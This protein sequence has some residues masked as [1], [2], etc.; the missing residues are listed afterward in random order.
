MELSGIL[1]G[2]LYFFLMYKYP[3]EYGGAQLL[4]T[5]NIL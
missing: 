5:P 3:E 1:I 2:H 4:T